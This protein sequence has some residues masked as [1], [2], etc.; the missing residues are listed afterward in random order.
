MMK[1]EEIKTE[2]KEHKIVIA[3]TA[4][5][6]ALLIV[7]IAM[8]VTS[9]PITIDKTEESDSSTEQIIVDSHADDIEQIILDINTSDIEVI[10]NKHND[11]ADVIMGTLG[12][13][14]KDLVSYAAAVDSRQEAVNSIAIVKPKDETF[15]KVM[16][17]LLNYITQKQL[18]YSNNSLES[19]EQYNAV[20]NGKVGICNGYL[21]L[22]V[23]SDSN[24]IMNT[25]E[26][27]I[28]ELK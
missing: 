5:I 10:S 7:I 12:V 6:L 14:I 27:R 18:Y 2:F 20:L 25:I 13:D 26:S 24:N 19:T 28:K 17:N 16:D 1:L 22:V 15:D 23:H 8:V 11:Q 9:K 4:A 3:I 21:I